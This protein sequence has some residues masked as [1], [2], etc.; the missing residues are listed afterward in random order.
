M[1]IPHL[2]TVTVLSN[3]MTLVPPAL[4]DGMDHNNSFCVF[5]EVDSR[6]LADAFRIYRYISVQVIKPVNR[7]ST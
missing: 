2:E 3:V 1:P 5:L 7:K 6:L 4:S